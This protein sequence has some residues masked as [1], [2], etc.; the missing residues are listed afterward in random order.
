MVQVENGFVTLRLRFFKTGPLQYI[1]HLDLVRTLNK[2]LVRTHLPLWY[3]E[4]FNPKPKLS[5]VANLSI[6]TESVC[7]YMDIRLT[8]VMDPDEVRRRLNANMTPDMQITEAYYPDTKLT[9]M[10][11][12]RYDIRI[13]TVGADDD[14]AARCEQVLGADRLMVVKRAK[15]GSPT[16]ADIRPSVREAHVRCE[17]RELRIDAVL[18]LLNPE[19][20]ITALRESVGI[21]RDPDL[22]RESY[23]ILRTGAYREDMTPFR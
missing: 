15:D 7:E 1:S 12:L 11:W 21:L 17:E 13:R 19:Y 5:F 14:M 8:E 20:L 9:D 16:P 3:T 22:T 4:G 2:I 18:G 10:H 23:S 6:G